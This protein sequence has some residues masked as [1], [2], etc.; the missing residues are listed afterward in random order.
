[1]KIGSSPL[2]L[3]PGQEQKLEDHTENLKSIEKDAYLKLKENKIIMDED[4]E[5]AIRVALRN[6]KDFAIPFRLQE[7]IVWKYAFTPEEEIQKLLNPTKEEKP[8]EKKEPEKEDETEEEVPKAWEVKKEEIKQAKE[9]SKK[10]NAGWFLPEGTTC[11]SM[12]YE[13]P[14]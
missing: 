10:D 5:P 8:Q 6:I 13:I 12:H 1:M 7:K 11:S 4:E 14:I 9:E 3:L 2:Y